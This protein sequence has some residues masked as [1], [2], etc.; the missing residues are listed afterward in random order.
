MYSEEESIN[1][2]NFT[3]ENK[4]NYNILNIVL[5]LHWT[6]ETPKISYQ[7]IIKRDSS[8]KDKTLISI[9]VHQLI[10]CLSYWLLLS[11]L[12]HW[13]KGKRWKTKGSLVHE[14]P[15]TV[16][17]LLIFR[18]EKLTWVKWNLLKSDKSN[19]QI[20]WLFDL[21]DRNPNLIHLLSGKQVL[22]IGLMDHKIIILTIAFW[23][24]TNQPVDRLPDT[25]L[26]W[27]HVA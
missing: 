9:F 27:R 11:V 6:H 16:D 24:V 10:F 26:K 18:E 15:A 25:G 22:T 8:K 12:Y 14:A 5:Q 7:P 21:T 4:L 1:D 19:N 17:K 23:L 20:G 3:E 13:T 2:R